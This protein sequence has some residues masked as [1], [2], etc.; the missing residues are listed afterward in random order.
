MARTLAVVGCG[1]V[2]GS[3]LRA[4]HRSRGARLLAV[5]TDPATRA[6]IARELAVP[7]VE[8]VPQGLSDALVVLAAPLPAILSLLATLGPRLGPGCVVSDVC[9]LK[10]P[11]LLAARALPPHVPFVGA[12]PMAGREKGGFRASDAQLFR[13]RTIAL[14]AAPGTDPGAIAEVEQMWREV[15]RDV[16]HCDAAAH[17][18]AVARVSHLPFLVAAA[19]SEVAG[20]ADAL[21]RL[22][23]AGGLRDTTRVAEDATIRPVVQANPF[24]PALAREAGQLLERWAAE[25]ERGGSIEAELAH[26]AQRRRE[27]F[28][29]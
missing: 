16:L 20:H 3:L 27:L 15:G 24:L 12:H 7:V 18:A 13:D 14:A 25:L 2:G 17:D 10:V 26:A 1:L 5:D 28:S 29:R 9:G 19:L 23:A 21:A 8:E 11:V 4:L 22:L 6:A